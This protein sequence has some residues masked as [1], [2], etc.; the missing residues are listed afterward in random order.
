MNV[1]LKRTVFS[2]VVVVIAATVGLAIFLLTFNPNA[3]K[4][5]IQNL[6][7]EHY[8]R[9][10]TIKGDI[11]LSLF[12]RIGLSVRDVSLSNREGEDVFV[13]IDGAR[14]AVAIW[15]LLSN[16][17][18]VDHVAV[19]GLKA[20]VTRDA[21]GRF[22][23]DDL[24][25]SGPGTAGAPPAA[26]TTGAA[27]AATAP[28]ALAASEV[29]RTE[30]DIDIA[31][32]ELKD[33]QIHYLD[34]REGLSAT[35]SGIEA[36][37]GRV[38]YDQPFDVSVKGAL[39]GQDPKLDA[40]FEAQAL[41]RLNPAQRGYGAQKINVQFTGRAGNLD[42]AVAALKGNLAYNGTERTFSAGN[43]ELTVSGDVLGAHPVAGLKATLSA[44]QIRLDQRNNEL[45]IDKLALRASGKGEHG[46][47]EVAFD[48]PSLAISPESAQGEPVTGTVKVSGEDKLAL[49]FGLEGLAGNAN[50]LRLRAMT[51][52]GGIAHG[53]RLTRLQ[54]ASPVTWDRS[55]RKG[56]LSAIKGDLSIRDPASPRP[57]FEFP[58][59]GSV[60]L[61]QIKDTLDADINAVIEGGQFAF[62]SQTQRLA[63]PQTRFSLTADKLD[64]NRWLEPPPS[65]AAK[66]PKDKD[67][68]GAAAVDDKAAEAAPQAAATPA[69]ETRI[70]LSFLEGQ[71]IAGTIKI[72]DLRVRDLQ[73]RGLSA[74]VGIQKNALQ[75]SKL[76][77]SLYEGTLSGSFSATSAQALAAQLALDK[78]AVEPFMRAL[79]GQGR[80]SGTAGV[81]VDVRAQGDTVDAVL[82][83]LEGRVTWQVR[84]GAVHGISASQSLEDAA[85]VLGNV[86]KGQPGA[87]S[88][89]FEENRRTTFSA[90]DGRVDF[91]RGQGK[92]SKLSL[93][94]DLVRVSEGRPAGIDLPAR[95][96]D[97]VLNVQ[98]TSRAPKPLA[99]VIG[100]LLGATLPLRISGPFDHPAYEVQWSGVRNQAIK[101]AVKSGLMELLPGGLIPSATPS[102][103]QAGPAAPPAPAKSPDPVKRIGEAL[104][105][106]LG[107]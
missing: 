65:P 77:A 40:H 71:D 69:A 17:L 61:D 51:L 103:A 21:D 18:V 10:L 86:L 48:A 35:V 88:N 14:F 66:A 83:A 74:D 63:D 27:V 56:S 53:D 95:R 41:L 54:L 78:V 58:M 98:I 92:L 79:T 31:G 50:E 93:V 9:T 7:Y 30:L 4:D 64:L 3:Y 11:G 94:S 85:A 13:S 38:T 33:G 25:A 73:L 104:K 22:N 5:K 76:V 34:Q 46:D 23:F 36:A 91:L 28:V 52:D 49:A 89:P 70:D 6:V 44:P 16:R 19:S 97:L 81:R 26:G 32:L 43:L 42:K 55:L 8:H 45:Q 29:Q 67:G 75:V 20:W 59:I 82:R 106:L 100:P 87:M 102:G 84:D 2:L 12:P 60:H 62:K 39:V 24:V 47:M 72:D 90:F 105:G 80:L 15:P 101:D 107:Q 99:G 1:W 96:L 57:E 68:G 37:T